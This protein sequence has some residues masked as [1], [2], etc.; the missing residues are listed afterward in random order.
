ME[1]QIRYILSQDIFLLTFSCS[2]SL[3]SMYFFE[4]MRFKIDHSNHF[5]DDDCHRHTGLPHFSAALRQVQQSAGQT[6]GDGG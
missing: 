1:K 3:L 2:F 6:S 4:I 5:G